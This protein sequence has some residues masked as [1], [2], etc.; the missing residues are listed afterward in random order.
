VATRLS[1]PAARRRAEVISARI[2]RAL[3]EVSRRGSGCG[4]LLG[5]TD[6]KSPTYHGLTVE[7]RFSLSWV[8]A[9]SGCWTWVAGVK[10]TGYGVIRQDEEQYAHRISYQLFV[11][12]ITPT[13]EID[14]LCRNRAC[15]NP[16]HLEPV[17]QRENL[18][19]ALVARKRCKSGRHERTPEN[20]FT[21]TNG[22]KT[23]HPCL[24]DSYRRADA[25]RPQA[26]VR[27]RQRAAA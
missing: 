9:E 2:G 25:K 3:A 7:Q 5:P 4:D 18:H 24:K 20:T 10:N 19:R 26:H 23:C 1:K 12:P 11:G 17:T 6:R 13:L 14:H 16:E 15:V 27:M 21:R 22:I 8:L